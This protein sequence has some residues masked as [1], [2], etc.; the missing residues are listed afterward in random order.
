[1]P[2]I[3]ISYSRADSDFVT[4]LESNL[5]DLGFDVLLD[6]KH[7]LGSRSTVREIHSK[8][9]QSDYLIPVMSANSLRSEWVRPVEIAWAHQLQKEGRRIRILP[10]LLRKMRSSFSELAGVNYIDFT[11]EYELA[12][13][14]LVQSLPSSEYDE[15]Y[16]LR[17][18]LDEQT[19]QERSLLSVLRK[20]ATRPRKSR[21]TPHWQTLSAREFLEEIRSVVNNEEFLDSAYWWLIVHGVLR[22]NDIDRFWDKKDTYKDSRKYARI[23]PRGAAL[24]E[25]LST[26]STDDASR[27]ATRL[28]PASSRAPAKNRRAKP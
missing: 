7:L 1:M 21:K 3:F 9:S 23:S 8:I 17:E 10:V 19:I 14:R 11:V 25:D 5:S 6:K 15:L 26:E 12:L 24:M 16:H 20:V 4:K 2:K 27:E 18:Q 13:A 28:R 22:F